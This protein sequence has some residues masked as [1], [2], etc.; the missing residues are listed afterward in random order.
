[1]YINNEIDVK[2]LFG[3]SSFCLFSFAV[4]IG[5]CSGDV[6]IVVVAEEGTLLCVICVEPH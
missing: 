4:L 3:K 6:R 1:M 5:Y 2:Q